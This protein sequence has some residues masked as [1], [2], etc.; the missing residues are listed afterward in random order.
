MNYNLSQF[1]SQTKQKVSTL[2]TLKKLL[3]LIAE[4]RKTLYFAFSAILVNS[5]INLLGPFLIGRAIDKY[6]Q[7][8]QY[9]GVLTYSAILLGLYAIGLAASYLQ[10]KLMGGVGQ[11]LLF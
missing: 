1:I 8:K 4:E 2:E 6:V 5:G 3:A 9:N 11:R 10:T 7:T